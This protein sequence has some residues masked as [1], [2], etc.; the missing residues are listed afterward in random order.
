MKI[1]VLSLLSFVL[2]G[3]VMITGIEVQAKAPNGN[4]ANGSGAVYEKTGQATDVRAQAFLS[5]GPYYQ[6]SYA[7]DLREVS[8]NCTI[9]HCDT[10]YQVD[11][12]I[13]QSTMTSA[14]DSPYMG[15]HS[16]MTKDSFTTFYAHGHYFS[17]YM[18]PVKT[19][20]ETHVI[21]SETY[22]Y[23]HYFEGTFT[24]KLDTKEL[25]KTEYLRRCPLPTLFSQ[26]GWSEDAWYD[27]RLYLIYF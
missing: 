7:S 20:K 2:I 27:Y 19:V 15:F 18:S 11:V 22:Q 10:Q 24:T 9:D 16:F 23:K 13:V 3:I 14:P 25:C 17:A 12:K 1:R 21:K 5:T 26:W 4:F 8:N 6:I